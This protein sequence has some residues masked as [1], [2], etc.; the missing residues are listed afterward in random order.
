VPLRKDDQVI[1]FLTA[2]RLEVRPYSEPEIAL[3]ES[4]AQQAV[5]A[6]ENARLLGELRDSLDRQTATTDVLR[7]I[8]GSPG[9]LRPVFETVLEKAMRLCEADCGVFLLKEGEMLRV[10]GERAMPPALLQWLIDTPERLDARSHTARTMRER[11]TLNIADTKDTPAYR[12]GVAY[13]RAAVDLGHARSMCLLPLATDDAELGI[14]AIFRQEVRPFTEKQVALVQ[15]F[16][17]QAVIAMQNARL[18]DAL[19]ESLERQTATAEVLQVINANPG[20]LVPVFE[21]MLERAIR[22]CN[23]DFGYLLRYEGGLFRIVAGHDDPG[24]NIGRA[25]DAPPGTALAAVRD[26]EAVV[27][28][29]DLADTDLYRQR[30]PSRVALVEDAGART[31]VWVALRR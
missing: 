14:F 29:A 28:I 30:E 23:A 19:R 11:R 3:L 31:V 16:A 8:N 18:L 5:I 7:V 10:A 27:Q 6:I 4:F 21:A 24:S 22:L 13:T 17:D 12:E 25:F 15:N 26:G 1:G 9:E 20:E 2:N